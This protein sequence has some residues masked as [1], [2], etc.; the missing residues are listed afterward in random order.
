MGIKNLDDALLAALQSET[1]NRKRFVFVEPHEV[2]STHLKVSS[3]DAANP[4]SR[5][6]APVNRD[7]VVAPFGP[8]WDEF[9]TEA[10]NL[11]LEIVLMP[12]TQER[13][14]SMIALANEVPTI[15]INSTMPGTIKG[16][17]PFQV[18]GYN[19]LKDE[20]AGWLHWSTGTGKTVGAAALTKYHQVEG[21]FDLAIWA[22]KAHNKKNTA[23]ALEAL[24]GIET[25]IV[26]G[27]PAKRKKLYGEI[28]Q[29]MAAGEQPVIIVNYEQFRGDK[30]FFTALVAGH[31]V[32]M[33]MDEAPTKLRNRK[34]QTWKA[35][36]G[37]LYSTEFKGHPMPDPKGLRPSELRAYV[38]SATPIENS[39]MDFYN[40]VRLISPKALGSVTQFEKEHVTWGTM[41]IVGRGGR[42]IETKQ[43]TGFRNLDEI[44]IK[45]AHL[46]HQVDK[47][48]PDIA[49][50]FPA[51]IQDEI[52]VD[53]SDHQKK[54]YR[55]LAD[56]YAAVIEKFVSL[57]KGE[58]L[59]DAD[60]R[61]LQ[62]LRAVFTVL[63]MIVDDPALVLDAAARYEADPETGSE[64]AFEFVNAVADDSQFLDDGE[65]TRVAKLEALRE[66]VEDNDAKVIAFSTHGAPFQA[67][68]SKWLDAWGI[69]HVVY[70][71]SMTM[72]QKQDAED[73]FKSDPNCKLFLSSDAGSDSINLDC[74]N[75][76]VHINLPW[77]PATFEQRENRQHRITSKFEHVR[78]VTLMTETL[79]EEHKAEILEMKRSYQVAVKESAGGVSA[80]LREMD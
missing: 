61:E 36:A 5:I 31:K 59:T 65:E 74:A 62:K 2:Y 30:D 39:P 73:R 19:M 51:V 55:K 33:V 75:L 53:L 47:N 56:R 20:R 70:N 68:V 79:P 38:T 14:D 69:G 6:A 25:I 76:A 57:Q 54:L 66:L 34:T 67:R 37:I 8:K 11:G 27:T 58:Y 29:K 9:V 28:A 64:V 12:G 43:I 7:F 21:N 18:A 26:H 4:Q 50:Q 3:F 13:I 46:T 49:A 24:V 10:Q 32:M 44:G 80:A 17:L 63:Q 77:K 72:N 41:R 52:I 22:V 40:V 23:R 71:G 42:I 60:K 1:V 15:E 78:A 35:L 48:D 45:V 16:M